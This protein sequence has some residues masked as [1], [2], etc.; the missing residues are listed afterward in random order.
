MKP[1]LLQRNGPIKL[2]GEALKKKKILKKYLAFNTCYINDKI[3]KYVLY[4]KYLVDNKGSNNI[5]NVLTINY[6]K[7]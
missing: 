2:A 7:I 5:V 6:I 4:N 3:N 1:L